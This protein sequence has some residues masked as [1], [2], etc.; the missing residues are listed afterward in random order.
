MTQRAMDFLTSVSGGVRPPSSSDRPARLAV[1]DPAFNPSTYPATLPK[2]TY[3]GES[4]LS[5]RPLSVAS[6]YV[7][8]PGDRVYVGPVGTTYA[9]LGPVSSSVPTEVGVGSPTSHTGI[10]VETT[11]L[12]VPSFTFKAGW[13]Y[14][15]E[16]AQRPYGTAGAQALFRLRKTN[17]SGTDWGEYGR[18]RLEGTSAANSAMASGSVILYRSAS[19]D[20]VATFVLTVAPDSGTVN[21]FASAATPRWIMVSPLG[22]YQRFSAIGVAVS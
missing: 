14:R 6:L 1:I 16:I 21:L 12:T 15:V 22:P 7:P 8:I 3:E 9:I 18:V 13:A 19:T 5:D 11:T 2:V 17:A 10:T 20:L 4:V